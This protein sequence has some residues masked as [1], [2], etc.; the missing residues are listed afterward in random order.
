L[1]SQAHNFEPLTYDS[2]QWRGRSKLKTGTLAAG[3]AA[4]AEPVMPEYP[5]L[6]APTP[7]DFK[8]RRQI[9]VRTT[10]Y[11]SKVDGLLW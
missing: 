8:D 9:K 4:F 10:N 6:P 2:L 7:E 5:K 3:G 11:G 1:L